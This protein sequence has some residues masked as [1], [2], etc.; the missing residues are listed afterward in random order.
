MMP[1]ELGWLKNKW[2]W[3]GIGS[4]SALAVVVSFFRDA[5]TSES[6]PFSDVMELAREGDVLWIEVRGNGLTVLTVDG[7]TYASRVSDGAEVIPALQADGV[8]VGG[9]GS[10]VVSYVDPPAYGNWVALAVNLLFCVAVGVAIYVAVRL[11][12]R[13]TQNGR[14]VRDGDASTDRALTPDPPSQAPALR[15]DGEGAGG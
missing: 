11:A 7:E 5:E 13:H 8:E 10:V 2:I 6:I 1:A 15:E 3:I 12:I 14:K 9:E 4:V